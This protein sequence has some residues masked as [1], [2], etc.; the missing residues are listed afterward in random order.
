MNN[1]AERGFHAEI[2]RVTRVQLCIRKW[3]E[4]TREDWRVQCTYT[5]MYSTRTCWTRTCT[6][7]YA[8]ARACAHVHAHTHTHTH[9]HA[10]THI[11]TCSRTHTHTHKHTHRCSHTHT[12]THKCTC[13]TQRHTRMYA[14][15]RTH[16][17]TQETKYLFFLLSNGHAD[18][19]DVDLLQCTIR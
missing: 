7:T 8:C 15:A 14:Y 16:T 19:L 1:T 13:R 17:Q 12:Q 18:C 9:T 4:V 3:E 2:S 6:H 10:H 5:R 11:H